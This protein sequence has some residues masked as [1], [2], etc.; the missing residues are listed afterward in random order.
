M[1]LAH[2][3]DI[4]WFRKCVTQGWIQCFD[5]G[6]DR[7]IYSCKYRRVTSPTV[8]KGNV[9]NDAL[10]RII[11]RVW[12]FAHLVDIA[13]TMKPL[14]LFFTL[15]WVWHE[16][17]NFSFL[18]SWKPLLVGECQACWCWWT[19]SRPRRVRTWGSEIGCPNNAGRR[20]LIVSVFAW[21]YI[22]CCV[23]RTQHKEV[24]ISCTG[25]TRIGFLQEL[26]CCSFCL[27][28]ICSDMGTDRKPI[29]SQPRSNGRIWEK[30]SLLARWGK[31]KNKSAK[32]HIDEDICTIQ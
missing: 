27:T 15:P 25:C 19:P 23:Y 29:L 24:P 12:V 17:P 28:I 22:L 4:S 30:N 21:Y 1:Q 31:Y 18:L 9:W 5:R 8:M 3:T 16:A 32:L 14:E 11:C 20:S 6:K 2:L 10:T 13:Q 26:L 7:D